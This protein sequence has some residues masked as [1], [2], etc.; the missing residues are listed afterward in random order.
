M[1]EY[2]IIDFLKGMVHPAMCVVCGKNCPEFLCLDCISMILPMDLN[3][4]CS[5][6][7]AVLCL[8]T[9]GE[10]I[11]RS[12]KESGL[13]FTRHQSFTLYSG[14]MKKIIKKFKYDKIYGLDIVLSGLLH[15]VYRKYFSGKL[16]DCV[17]TVPGEHTKKLTE[18]FSKI[19]KIPFKGNI[20]K[21]RNTHKQSGLDL[22]A[23]RI[24][25]LDAFKL[26]N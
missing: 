5:Y 25:I 4:C 23:R 10:G 9:T 14:N 2:G 12:C 21:I 18:R 19:V 3:K 17:E 24:N 16:I 15:K 13:N 7:G 22:E 20:I 11:C 6:C 26:K 1:P 8:P